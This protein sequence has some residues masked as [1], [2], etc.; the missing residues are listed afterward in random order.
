MKLALAILLVNSVSS[1]NP[2]S[3]KNLKENFCMNI[4]IF[5]ENLVK[6]KG[7]LKEMGLPQSNTVSKKTTSSGKAVTDIK[8]I[9][10]SNEKIARGFLGEIRHLS[11][12]DNSLVIKKV[13]ILFDNQEKDVYIEL[14][15]SEIEVIRIMQEIRPPIT[16]KLYGC[17]VEKVMSNQASA[18]QNGKNPSD[19]QNTSYYLV[20]DKFD[21]SLN[22]EKVQKIF[23]EQA[24]P[25]QRLK[26]YKKLVEMFQKI[27]KLDYIHE[28]IK[29]DN[30]MVVDSNKK[31]DEL[32]YRVIDFGLTTKEKEYVFYA[33]E[34]FCSPNKVPLGLRNGGKVLAEKFDD[35]YA[36]TMTFMAMEIEIDKVYF[37]YDKKNQIKVEITED[38]EE[39]DTL[40]DNNRTQENLDHMIEDVNRKKTKDEVMID[41]I[42]RSSSRQCRQTIFENCKTILEEEINGTPR[43]EF[44]VKIIKKVVVWDENDSDN[45]NSDSKKSIRWKNSNQ[46]SKNQSQKP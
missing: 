5:N 28:D 14:I 26:A 36:L 39:E 19:L 17:A 29:P 15:K 8:K 31:I 37:G 33:N 38:V 13:E 22:S 20:Q 4:T 6:A 35:I 34:F 11:N 23:R 7:N 9:F 3:D 46:L 32:E 24:N 43:N 41:C 10:E 44:L 25:L 12:L 42:S 45:E 2:P 18:Q 21:A 30:I 27:H 40:S 1:P 16:Y